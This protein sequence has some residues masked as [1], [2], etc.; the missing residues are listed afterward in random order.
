MTNRDDGHIDLSTNPHP[1]TRTEHNKLLD[2][3]ITARLMK[4]E[5][6]KKAVKEALREYTQCELKKLRGRLLGWIAAGCLAIATV[7]LVVDMVANRSTFF[8]KD[9]ISGTRTR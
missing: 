1:L 7:I 8:W 3:D 9:L 5:E 4:Q 2:K 6:T